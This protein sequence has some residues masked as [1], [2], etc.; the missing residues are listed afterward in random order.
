MTQRPVATSVTSLIR[1]EVF[2]QEEYVPV[3]PIDVLAER[4]GIPADQIRKLD[5]NEN[6]YGSPP[7]VRAAL[8]DLDSVHIYPDPQHRHLRATLAEY[9]DCPADQ[10]LCG[11]GSDEL[12]DLVFRIFLA[13]GDE[14]IDCPPSFGMYSFDATICSARVV[15]VDRREDFRLNLSAIE[16]AVT[17]RTKLI[18]L[19]SPNNPTGN[20]VSDAELEALL[21][22]GPVVLL[23]EAYAEFAGRSFVRRVLEEPNLIVLRT[24]SKWAGLAGLRVGYGVFPPEVIAQLWKVKQPYNVNVAGLVAAEAAIRARVAWQPQIDKII[25]ERAR[26]FAALQ[27]SAILT[28]LPSESN[29][30]LCRVDPRITAGDLRD[31]LARRGIFVRYFD[32]PGLRNAI[33]VSVGRPEDT[34]ALAAALR[35]LP[36]TP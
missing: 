35:D 32:K 12:I 34:D 1:P 16:A 15:A 18:V 29:F 26:L 6:P 14:I 9:V 23:D 8:R 21:D 36:E 2:S 30:I 28:P 3:E 20:S 19:C 33:R 10:I 31:R 24:F 11:N 22:L 4:F 27:Q 17:D 13:P 25:A 7:E 5:G